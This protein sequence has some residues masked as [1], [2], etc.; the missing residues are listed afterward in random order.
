MP[1][2]PKL[3][4]LR[5]QLYAIA[6]LPFWLVLSINAQAQTNCTTLQWQPVQRNNVIE[7]QK[8]PEFSLPFTIIYEG[9]RFGDTQSL[10]LKHGFSHLAKFSGNEAA[11]LSPSKRATTWYHIATGTVP[12][13]PWG[14]RN[15]ESPWNNNL[16]LFRSTWNNQILGMANVFSDSRA[17][18]VP[19]YDIIAMDIERIHDTD[20]EILTIKNNA[21]VP[22]T[23]RNLSDAAFTERY[24]RDIQK[25]Y[26]SPVDWLKE[27]K[28]PANTK[29]GSYSD[30]L[31][32]GNFN[33]WLA[34]KA[35][36]WKDWTESPN[37]VLHLMRDTTTNKIGGGFYQKLDILTPSCYYY[38]TYESQGLGKDYLAYL[39]FVIEAN[40]HWSDKPIIPYVWLRYHDYFNPTVPFVPP[41]VAEATA[42][43]PFFSGAKGL[44]LW[45]GPVESQSFNYA[46][47]EYFIA[48]LHRLSQYKQFFEGNYELVIPQP[49]IESARASSPIWRAVVKDGQI[50]VAAQ[51][52]Y[53][54]SD[55]ETKEITVSYKNWQQNITLRGRE[56]FLCTFDRNTINGLMLTTLQ[57][58]GLKAFPNPA[59]KSINYQIEAGFNGTAE[60]ELIDMAGRV[61]K[62]ESFGLSR[63]RQNKTLSLAH[64]SAG[65]Y[66]LR[67]RANQ[68]EATQKIVVVE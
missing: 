19:N 24:K 14:E 42:I 15:I 12:V 60:V 23:Y 25:L 1:L 43:F 61:C 16:N 10:P 2:L 33:N 20:R 48:G 34:L 66:L 28:I 62:T 56:V 59:Q 68:Y 50:L 22:P 44:W 55:T 45:E 4:K 30:V 31:V 17:S 7:W 39:L 36:T 47:Y 52:P 49:A 6:I 51:N 27:K 63:G 46:T 67:I 57:L 40:R 65:L 53:A 8:F 64:L 32:R 18:G 54:N 41:F 3:I 29:I 5:G 13:Q 9:P 37:S 26:A 58:Y 11:D 21:L 38:Y 35:T